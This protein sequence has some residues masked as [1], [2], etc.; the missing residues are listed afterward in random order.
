MGYGTFNEQ[1]RA[2]CP[3]KTHL[4][5]RCKNGYTRQSIP[6][7]HISCST[8]ESQDGEEPSRDSAISMSPDDH[9]FSPT[10]IR[11]G[12]S[13]SSINLWAEETNQNQLEQEEEEDE[14]ASLTS[15]PFP[16]S[17]SSETDPLIS[18]AEPSNARWY[19]RLSNIYSAFFYTTT[20]QT[21]KPASTQSLGY[22]FTQ[23][24]S[25]ALSKPTD[26]TITLTYGTLHEFL[27]HSKINHLLRD[28][29]PRK[30]GQKCIGTSPRTTSSS[31]ITYRSSA[32]TSENRRY[33]FTVTTDLTVHRYGKPLEYYGKDFLHVRKTVEDTRDENPEADAEAWK[34]QQQQQQLREAEEQQQAAATTKT[35]RKKLSSFELDEMTAS[36]S[37]SSSST[38]F[39]A[40]PSSSSP[41]LLDSPQPSLTTAKTKTNLPLSPT[42]NDLNYIP[43]NISSNPGKR[44]LISTI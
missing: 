25:I 37:S 28:T 17:S 12:S 16:S 5:S 22:T 10:L 14:E 39:S 27:S 40:L 26:L 31:F 38:S 7:I 1:N 36:S 13:Q 19:R 24:A 23:P 30:T 44:S 41:S 9:P 42:P 8:T 18:H 29:K 32:P 34:V 3:S 2:P 43:F 33:N 4:A 21:P 35:G 11:P 15:S 6:K 20:S